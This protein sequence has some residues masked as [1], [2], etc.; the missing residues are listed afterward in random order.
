M[1]ERYSVG[2]SPRDRHVGYLGTKANLSNEDRHEKCEAS[3]I[4]D[5]QK[6]N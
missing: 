1:L 4:Q 3:T 2:E 6:V 5:Y